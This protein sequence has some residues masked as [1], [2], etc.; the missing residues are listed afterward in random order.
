MKKRETNTSLALFYNS[1]NI[2]SGVDVV[3]AIIQSVTNVGIGL[4]FA[5]IYLR[6]GS[7]WALIFIHTLIDTAGLAP[8][9]FLYQSEV[10]VISSLTWTS[11]IGGLIFALISIFLLRPSKCKEVLARLNTKCCE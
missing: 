1:L 9:V 3:S 11:L 10:E 2:L 4:L 7:I 5:A 6:S 8:S